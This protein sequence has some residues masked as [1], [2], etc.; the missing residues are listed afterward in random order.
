MNNQTPCMSVDPSSWLGAAALAV[1]TG[2]ALIVS[3][4][5]GM[6]VKLAAFVY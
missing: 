3:I 6:L 2:A 1:M 5:T 4:A